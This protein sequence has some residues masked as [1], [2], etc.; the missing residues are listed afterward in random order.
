MAVNKDILKFFTKNNIHSLWHFTDIRNLPLINQLKGLRGKT[1]LEGNGHWN[2]IFP[3]GNKL[4]QDLDRG[5]GN[6]DKISLNFTPHTPMVYYRK[7]ESHLVFIEIDATIATEEGVYFTNCNATRCRNGQ[8]RKQGIE[9]LSNVKFDIING[10]P[11]PWDGDWIKYVQAEVLVPEHIPFGLFKS[12]HF[13]SQASLE[14]GKYLLENSHELFKVV[15]GTFADID[16]KKG[17]AIEFPYLVDVVIS[18]D[19]ITESNAFHTTSSVRRILEEKPFW[20]VANL[21]ANSGTR[22]LIRIKPTGDSKEI[23]FNKTSNWRW[24]P[25]F[26]IFG[27]HDNIELEVYINDILWLVR[28]LRVKT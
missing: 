20:V 21:N 3:G 25:E 9:G 12:I 11:K 8:L 27:H 14:H 13:I 10:P 24:W 23:T 22:G 6:W 28:K 15:E 17:L 7:R 4:S 18:N 2:Y 26:T 5:L 1:Y 16:Y 19:E